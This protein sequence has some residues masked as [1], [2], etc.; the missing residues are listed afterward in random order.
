MNY[1]LQVT[2]QRALRLAEISK[3]LAVG[4]ERALHVGGKREDLWRAA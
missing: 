4:I 2:L 1:S 3:Q